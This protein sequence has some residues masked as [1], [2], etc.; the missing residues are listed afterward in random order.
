MIASV[1][2]FILNFVR[3]IEV[4][5]LNKSEFLSKKEVVKMKTCIDHLM[6]DSKFTTKGSLCEFR[7]HLNRKRVSN[8]ND[9]NLVLLPK[10][11]GY[12][13]GT[14]TLCYLEYQRLRLDRF[15]VFYLFLRLA[16]ERITRVQRFT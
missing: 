12:R 11:D 3:P 10:I 4:Y 13:H 9:T 2:D 5:V 6:K 8:A 14:Y 16:Q 7:G 1:V 15:S